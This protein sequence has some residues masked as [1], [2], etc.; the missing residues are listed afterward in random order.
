LCLVAEPLGCK[1]VGFLAALPRIGHA[2]ALFFGCDMQLKVV[3]PDGI[4]LEQIQN[5]LRALDAPQR[6]ARHRDLFF[7]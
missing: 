1:F 5:S 3:D 6:S 7:F 2:S 4:S